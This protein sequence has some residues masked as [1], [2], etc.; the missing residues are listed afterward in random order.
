MLNEHEL[1]ELQEELN[2]VDEEEWSIDAEREDAVDVVPLKSRRLVALHVMHFFIHNSKLG[3]G[4]VYGGAIRDGIIRNDFHD[5]MDID[6]SVNSKDKE[7]V[8]QS[9]VDW[10]K[11]NKYVVQHRKE[12]GKNVTECQVQS[13]NNILIS[14]E[15]VDTEFFKIRAEE[16]NESVVD[17]D[18]NNLKVSADG[19]D[20]KY[21]MHR[22]NPSKGEII[23]HIQEKTFKIVADKSKIKARVTKMKSR[24]W[25]LIR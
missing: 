13:D 19:I 3:T 5:E 17:L 24:G 22:S 7:I 9:L 1:F 25:K 4:Y 21:A 11:L 20:V 10:C 18:V 2:A 12:K 8:F 16:N 23:K 15:F 14:I 6:V